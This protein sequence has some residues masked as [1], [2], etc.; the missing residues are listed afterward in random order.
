[1]PYTPQN[2]T[3]FT[4][5]YAG[6]LAG[7]AAAEK[8]PSDPVP[9][10]PAVVGS[11]TVAGAY[12]QAFDAAW[13]AV[14]PNELQVLSIEECSAAVFIGQTPTPPLPPFTLPSN[15]TSL[16]EA[17]IAIV[18]AGSN[19]F[20]AQGVTPDPWSVGAS[21][22]TGATGAT[23]ATGTGP[24]GA[25]GATG[26]TGPTGATAATGATGATGASGTGPTGSTGATGAIGS[27]GATGTIGATGSTGATGPEQTLTPPSNGSWGTSAAP[28]L[29]VIDPQNVSG[30]ASD[31]NTYN[32]GAG[33]PLLSYKGLVNYWG[34]TEPLLRGTTY[35]IE[36][37]SSH[38]DNTD[39]VICNPY[40]IGG[41]VFTIQGATPATTAAVFTLNTAKSSAAGSNALLS[42][43]FSA[44]APATTKMVQ[45]TTAGKSSRAFIYTS[46]GGANW[47]LTQPVAVSSLPIATVPAE[48]NS[49][50]STDTVNFLALIAINIVEYAPTLIDDNAS[51]DNIGQLALCTVL[52]PTGGFGNVWLSNVYATDVL[53][54]RFVGSAVAPFPSDSV[55]SN[56]FLSGGAT[57][58]TPDNIILWA[59]TVQVAFTFGGPGEVIIDGDFIMGFGG[60]GTNG[61]FDIGRIYL[62]GEFGC[63]QGNVGAFQTVFAGSHVVYGNSS[64]QL[65][66]REGVRALMI[67][68]TFTA[69]FTA[70][71]VLT[72]IVLDT[73]DTASSIS[74]SAGIG[75][76]NGPSIQTSV[77]NLDAAAGPVGFGGTAF[78]MGQSSISNAI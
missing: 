16:C 51:F 24:T 63:F 50:A 31:A 45:N 72:G 28:T 10:D 75:T 9:T 77:A 34:T 58:V 39:P 76:I 14:V 27:T 3:V 30:H 70:P 32:G 71:D 17:L 23:G 36:W 44:G 42:G 7:I 8:T 78:N 59:G 43:S 73:T 12:A 68:G 20:T 15:W 35:T 46:A 52:D 22:G 67:G 40:L 48:V 18:T 64:A 19:Y 4:A 38:T 74:Y 26:S 60:G 25:T 61:A 47:N 29:V 49:W 57:W 65:L 69:A 53:F 6:A 66:I 54:E 2:K 55:Y 21:G 13:G 62:D 11:A 41:V 5:A 56:C 33:A 1:M 37:L